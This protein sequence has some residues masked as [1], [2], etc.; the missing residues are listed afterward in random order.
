MK[1]RNIRAAV[2]R[3]L[4]DEHRHI[5]LPAEFANLAVALR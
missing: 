5:G 4:A 3:R 2:I 1:Q